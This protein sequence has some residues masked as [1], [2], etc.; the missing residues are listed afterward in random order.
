[1]VGIILLGIILHTIM[2]L[3]LDDGRRHFT[4]FK[5]HGAS[6]KGGSQMT[7]QSVQAPPAP[8]TADA[9]NAWVQSMPQVYQTQM[10]YA[11]LEAQQQVEL[12]QQYAA[13]LAMAQRQ[14]NEILYPGTAGLQENLAEQASQGMNA[15]EMPDWMSRQY[16]N[17]LKSNLGTNVGSPIGAD[18]VSRGMQSQL[19]NQQKYYRDLGLTLAGRQPLATPQGPQTSN[20]M[21]NFS[22]SA[23]MGYMGQN[24]GNFASSS[25]PLSGQKTESAGFLWGLFG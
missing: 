2:L 13:P 17:E 25:R 18:Y 22:P 11:P 10:Q 3:I 6:G 12:A 5:P 19:F 7:V 21:G 1:M 4:T 9:I 24:Y 14:A 15:T 23:N 16:R 8:S 20:Y